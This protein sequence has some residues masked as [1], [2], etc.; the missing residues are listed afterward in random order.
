LDTFCDSSSLYDCD[1]NITLETLICGLSNSTLD[2]FTQLAL[3]N[4]SGLDANK[5]I[6]VTK[7]NLQQA[8]QSSADSIY[9]AE[10]YMVTVPVIL[11]MAIAVCFSLSLAVGYLP[12]MTSTILKARCGAIKTLHD[13]N[14]NTYRNGQDY[15]AYL[16]GSLFWG[17]LFAS[18]LA[19][20]AV[21]LILF[22]F[23]WQ[24]TAYFAIIVIATLIGIV[25]ATLARY[26]IVWFC[27]CSFWQAFYR[28][29]PASANVTLLGLEWSNFGL[30]ALFIFTRMCKFLAAAA[31]SVGRVDFPFLAKEA[32]K[33]GPMRLGTLPIHDRWKINSIFHSSPRTLF[34][35]RLFS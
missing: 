26:I 18:L 17:N 15:V 29:K 20:G 27:R 3:L 22:F 30:S 5:L 8:I 14:F 6:N 25:V 4:A 11:G 33:L 31:M 1:P 10:K 2:A 32:S 19:G 24:A 28:K 16:T 23:L 13:R 7:D 21:G 35:F 34:P 12:S 9:P